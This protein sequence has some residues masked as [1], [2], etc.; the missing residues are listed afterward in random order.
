MQALRSNDLSAIAQILEEFVAKYRLKIRPETP[1]HR[2][3]ARELL[4]AEV[5]IAGKMK[6]RVH[7]VF[8]EEYQGSTTRLRTVCPWRKRK[9]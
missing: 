7:G 2:T 1:E 4:K 9:C 8:G 3:L 5:V 6:E